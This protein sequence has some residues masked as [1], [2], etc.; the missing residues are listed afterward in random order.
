MKAAQCA[1]EPGLAGVDQKLKFISGVALTPRFEL[2]L[3]AFTSATLMDEMRALNPSIDYNALQFSIAVVLFRVTRINQLCQCLQACRDVKSSCANL[4]GRLEAL[5]NVA[6]DESDAR[7]L[8]NTSGLAKDLRIKVDILVQHLSAER[9]I[10][11]SVNSAGSADV[12]AVA[13]LVFEFLTGLVFTLLPCT[14]PLVQPACSQ[15]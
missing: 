15:I 14:F 10:C 9:S 2:L 7:T 8:T 13:F 12:T 11:S 3:A 4:V 1:E 6:A 5:Q